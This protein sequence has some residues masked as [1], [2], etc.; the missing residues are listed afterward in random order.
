[1]SAIFPPSCSERVTFVL[2]PKN[3]RRRRASRRT[4]ASRWGP[5]RPRWRRCS[6]TRV[7][8]RCASRA[9]PTR[10][11][12]AWHVTAGPSST[13]TWRC[14]SRC[15]TYGRRLPV[16]RSPSSRRPPASRSIGDRSRRCAF[17]AL[18]STRSRTRPDSPPPAT[19]SSIDACRSTSPT[20]SRTRLH[21]RSGARKQRAGGSSRSAPPSC[22]R[23][24]MP[25]HGMDSCMEGKA[26]P[27]SAS[28]RRAACEWSMRCS[29]ESTSPAR[30]ITSCCVRLQTRARCA[31]QASSS[32][33]TR[34]AHMNSAI[35]FLSK[36]RR[37]KAHFA[38]RYGMP[39]MFTRIL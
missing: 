33:L 19:R 18:R 38:E 9:R 3:G 15:G 36:G 34:F 11:G 6:A 8:C 32:R 20:A 25:L 26:W 22:A 31:A 13:R 27:R 28:T 30:A 37:G 24:S 7:S 5:S 14:R 10:S 1:M 21:L 4:T 35:R 29:R 2:A 16:R 39:A 12:R 23:S 17:A